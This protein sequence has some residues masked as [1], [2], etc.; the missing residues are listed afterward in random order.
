MASTAESAT[1]RISREAQRYSLLQLIRWIKAVDPGSQLRLR[2]NLQAGLAAREVDAAWKEDD[3]WYVQ[4]NLPGLYGRT[5]PLPAYITELL[6]QAE[7]SERT[8]PRALLDL[9]NQRLYELLLLTLSKGYPAVR[10]IEWE[11]TG[12]QQLLTRLLGVSPDDQKKLPPVSWLLQHFDLLTSSQ[13]SAAGLSKLLHSYLQFPVRV[14]ECASRKVLVDT[15]S[16][17]RLGEANHGLG[18]SA[19][20]GSRITDSNGKIRI[21]LG[22]ISH[23]QYSRLVSD[24]QQWQLLQTLVKIYLGVNLE[25]QLVFTLEPPRQQVSLGDAAWGFLGKNS[26]LLKQEDSGQRDYLTASLTLIKR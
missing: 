2:P 15:A 16:W 23:G 5:S 14:E 6:Q 13:R 7:Q 18:E 19:W 22:P 4:I 8:A 20:L 9:L 10:D 25:C 26:W 17:S 3:L 21:H 11:E 1:A 12:W 24:T